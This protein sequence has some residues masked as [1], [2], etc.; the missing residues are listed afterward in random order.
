MTN[1]NRIWHTATFGKGKFTF[2]EMKGH[3]FLQRKIKAFS[4]TTEPVS[5]KLDTKHVRVK[6]IQ[7]YSMKRFI[8]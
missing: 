4:G 2:L 5:T 6:R 3:V 7:V 8:F 1:F